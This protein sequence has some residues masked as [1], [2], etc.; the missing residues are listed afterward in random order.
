M[1]GTVL[2]QQIFSLQWYCFPYKS[3]YFEGNMHEVESTNQLSPMVNDQ[4]A[5][6]HVDYESN[7]MY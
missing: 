3:P 7:L 2:W 1:H 6:I 5:Q 4:W